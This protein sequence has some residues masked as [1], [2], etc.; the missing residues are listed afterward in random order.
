MYPNSAFIINNLGLDD[1]SL[2]DLNK[3]SKCDFTKS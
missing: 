2:N 3:I 1:L